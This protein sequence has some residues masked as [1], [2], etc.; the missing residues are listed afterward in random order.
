MMKHLAA[1]IMV[2]LTSGNCITCS[3]GQTNPPTLI[4]FWIGVPVAL[5]LCSFLLSKLLPEI[6]RGI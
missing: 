1:M 6:T 2:D 3:Q 5:H 4:R